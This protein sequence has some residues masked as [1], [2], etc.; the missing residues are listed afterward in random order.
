MKNYNQ[1]VFHELHS[2]T[3]NKNARERFLTF[4][5]NDNVSYLETK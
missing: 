3:E 2:P 4:V 1:E 5:R